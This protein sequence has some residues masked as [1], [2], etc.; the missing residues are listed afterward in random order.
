MCIYIKTKIPYCLLT[1]KFANPGQVSSQLKAKYMQLPQWDSY[2]P[3]ATK[4]S[5]SES[6]LVIFG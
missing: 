3:G 6:K 2:F 4:P 5:V 1:F